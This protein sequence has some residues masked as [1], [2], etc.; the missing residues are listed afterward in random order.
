MLIDFHTHCFADSIHEKAIASLVELSGGYRPYHDGSLAG[1]LEAMN[2]ADV[3]ISVVH[4]I[5][6]KGKQTTI[7]N[8]WVISIQSERIVPFGTIHP[9]FDD[10]EHEIERLK[11]EG[12][13]GIKFHPDYQ[14]FF[15]DDKRMYPIYEKTA[16]EGLI[17]LFHAGQDIAFPD[18]VRNTP[19]RFKKVLE[20]IPKLCAVDA[21]M[22]GHMMFDEVSEHLVGRD[23]YMDTSFAHYVLGDEG[24]TRLIKKHGAEH[25]LFGSDSPWDDAGE[26]LKTIDRLDFTTKEKEQ[27]LYKNAQNLL[28]I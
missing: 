21:H 15:V 26:L 9:D 4:S 27:I 13:K 18:V 23:F 22:G 7:I 8:D 10:W 16:E 12:I 1:L 6:T 5:A 2:K 20:D 14:G 28:G 19:A 3:D 17:A 24:F 11:K 25:V